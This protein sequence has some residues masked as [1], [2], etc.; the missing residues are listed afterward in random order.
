MLTAFFIMV[1]RDMSLRLLL[2]FPVGKRGLAV[3]LR[4]A[5]RPKTSQNYLRV[6]YDISFIHCITNLWMKH[7][8]R[9]LLVNTLSLADVG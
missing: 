5:R 4:S 9:A 2:P 3:H 6:S 7:L 1:Y 8:V